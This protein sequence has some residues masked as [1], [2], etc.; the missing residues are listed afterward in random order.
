MKTYCRC[1]AESGET[2]I[3]EVERAEE[4]VWGWTPVPV[5]RGELSIRGPYAEAWSSNGPGPSFAEAS[6]PISLLPHFSP[7]GLP[8]LDAND[9]E[10]ESDR[11]FHQSRPQSLPQDPCIPTLILD[12][13]P[14]FLSLQIKTVLSTTVRACAPPF[15]A[16][17][18]PQT[19]FVPTVPHR[20]E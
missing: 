1:G 12:S 2:L 5:G 9:P 16:P 3:S 6:T 15:A 4:L 11:F 18:T 19:D 10:G 17:L 14:I 8:A 7:P 20:V 13:C